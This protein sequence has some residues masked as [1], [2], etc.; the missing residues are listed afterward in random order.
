MAHR[1]QRQAVTLG[2]RRCPPYSRPI[3]PLR[4]GIAR[5]GPRRRRGRTAAAKARPR[6]AYYNLGMIWKGL[7]K[8]SEAISALTTFLDLHTARDERRAWAEASLA[9][10]AGGQ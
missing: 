4:A 5:L 2:C 8:K 7:G 10:L 1:Q 3:S 9:E 6:L